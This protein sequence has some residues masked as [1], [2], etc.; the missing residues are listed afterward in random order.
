MTWCVCKGRV[1]YCQ[2]GHETFAVNR[3]K[4]PPQVIEI[5]ARWLAGAGM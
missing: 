3:Q 4:K 5:A 1:A 2:P